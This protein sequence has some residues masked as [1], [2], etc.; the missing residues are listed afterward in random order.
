MYKTIVGSQLLKTQGSIINAS[1]THIF[2]SLGK[3]FIWIPRDTPEI[4]PFAL[5]YM[6]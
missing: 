3:C 2:W 1:S 5:P 6:R 4:L